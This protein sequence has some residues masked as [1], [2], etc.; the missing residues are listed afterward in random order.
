LG[1][2]EATELRTEGVIEVEEVDTTV[3]SLPKVRIGLETH[4]DFVVQWCVICV[5]WGRRG[6]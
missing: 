1:T 5:L 4:R 6:A 3:Y 2:T